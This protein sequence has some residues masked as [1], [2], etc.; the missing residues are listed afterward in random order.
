MTEI[1]GVRFKSGG[2]QYYF[3][4]NGQAV[5]PG[6]GVIIETSRGLEYGE[7][8]Q[9]NTMVEDEAV[10]QPLRPLVRL[11]TEKDLDTVAKNREKEARAFSICQE[12]I[13][14]HGLDMKLVEVEYN[15]EGNKILFFFTSE[16]RVAFPQLWA[17]LRTPLRSLKRAAKHPTRS[18]RRSWPPTLACP[19]FTSGER[20]TTVPVK[21]AG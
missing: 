6:Q 17:F 3:D 8:T 16:G 2:K 12:K 1:I 4:P 11:A 5:A 7:C 13:A 14:A 20:A 10:V 21:K 15:F 9:G 19:Y 18:S